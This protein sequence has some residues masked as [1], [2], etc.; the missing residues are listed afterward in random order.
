MPPLTRRHAVGLGLGALFAPALARADTQDIPMALQ[1][2]LKAPALRA[3]VSAFRQID[4]RAHYPDLAQVTLIADTSSKALHYWAVDGAEYR[5][6]PTSV[7]MSEDL[8]KR[9]RT[10]IV[11]KRAGPSW[12]PTASMLA[13]DP[14]LHPM[15][16]GPDN[17]LGTRA[18]YLSW[19]AYI[20][21][22][23]HDTRKIGRKSSSG[24][25]GLYNEQV[26]ALF[27]LCPIGTRVLI[28]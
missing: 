22:G 17:P 7:P 20:I 10:E 1:P 18:M 16:P 21:H 12:T 23:T 14:S 25:I 26:E 27:P 2:A 6:F 5:V 3:N 11:R 13:R 4:W 24:C 15:P 28:L 9:G 19:P 8:T